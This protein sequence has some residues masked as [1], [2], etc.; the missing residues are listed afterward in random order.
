MELSRVFKWVH[1]FYHLGDLEETECKKFLESAER[2]LCLSA[3]FW[4]HKSKPIYSRRYIKGKRAAFDCLLD[5]CFFIHGY[6]RKERKILACSGGGTSG[7][8]AA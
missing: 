8:I 2:A 6:Q 3:F 4:L 7:M 1:P 5:I